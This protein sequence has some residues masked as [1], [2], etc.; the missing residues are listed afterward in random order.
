MSIRRGA[1]MRCVTPNKRIPVSKRTCDV[2]I[3]NEVAADVRRANRAMH[4]P[5]EGDGTRQGIIKI[6]G[7]LVN[8]DKEAATPAFAGDIPAF[9]RIFGSQFVYP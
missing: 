3:N 7:M 8:S 4:L 5:L 2:T 1:M 6:A 9:S